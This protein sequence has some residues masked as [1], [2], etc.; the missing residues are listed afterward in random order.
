M[1][2][3][4]KTDPRRLLAR[5]A[6]T[7][8]SGQP[9]QVLDTVRAI[10]GNKGAIPINEEGKLAIEAWEI[11]QG[12]DDTKPTAA[13]LA[14]LE[15][16]IRMTRPA[17]L[18]H[19]GRPDDLVSPQQAAI[20]P[21][22]PAF[23][24]ALTPISHNI[25][26]VDRAAKSIANSETIGTGFLVAPGILLTNRHVLMQ[27]SRGTGV[28]EPGQ[29]VVRFEWEDNSFE[30]DNPVS[31][32]GVASLHPSLDAAL[33]RVELRDSESFPQIDTEALPDDADIVVVGYPAEDTVRNPLFL[34]ATFG[35]V[36]EVLRASPGLLTAREPFG[37]THDCSTLGGN[38]GSP[39]LSMKT[40]HVVG[41][42]RSGSFL[43]NNEAVDGESI[44]AFLAALRAAGAAT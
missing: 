37:F 6:R 43:W 31:I 16:M 18:I 27:L 1:N 17:P 10:V 42:H 33:L 20:F 19:G 11:L 36:F 22:W 28:L 34:N 14:A 23:Q 38:S 35:G 41:L 15:L 13:Q 40:G 4:P 9:A 3:T 32:L 26:R 39:V 29:G 24:A 21:E 30:A 25:G 2:E 7:F 12:D 44:A 8:P 5:A